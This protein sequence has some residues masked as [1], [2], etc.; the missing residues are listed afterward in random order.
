MCHGNLKEGARARQETQGWRGVS[1]TSKAEEDF[2]KPRRHPSP[3]KEGFQGNVSVPWISTIKVDLSR[4]QLPL[5]YYENSSSVLVYKRE[6]GIY[7]LPP[8]WGCLRFNTGTMVCIS[9]SKKCAMQ[10]TRFRSLGREDPLEKGMAIHSRILARRIPQ[11]EEPGGLQ[12]MGSQRV[13]H[14]WETKHMVTLYDL[15]RNCQSFPKPTILHSSHWFLYILANTC[16]FHFD[17]T[18]QWV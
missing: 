5:K 8:P 7:L 9:D 10:E 13:G 4:A 2:D 17:H 6:K 1:R 11:T 3:G 12:S 16:Y 18:V 14:D 15:L